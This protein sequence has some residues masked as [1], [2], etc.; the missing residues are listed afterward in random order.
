MDFVI[1]PGIIAYL[2]FGLPKVLN[3]FIVNMM[4]KNKTRKIDKLIDIGKLSNK[5]LTKFQEDK[6]YFYNDNMELEI[7]R[8]EVIYVN[9]DNKE[10][11]MLNIRKEM[12]NILKAERKGTK[13]EF[14]EATLK[15]A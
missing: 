3:P 14:T 10:E 1:I 12:F 6:S 8:P 7:R 2:P 11:L 15:E 4:D 9:N 13:F 5:N